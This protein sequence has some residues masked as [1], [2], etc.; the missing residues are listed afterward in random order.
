[1]QGKDFRLANNISEL[2]LRYVLS[3]AYCNRVAQTAISKC[4]AFPR[5]ASYLKQVCTGIYLPDI[6]AK[7]IEA[8]GSVSLLSGATIV[9]YAG[10][11]KD[12][13]PEGSD[14]MLDPASI[15]LEAGR[16]VDTTSEWPID[17]RWIVDYNSA[18]TR[19]SRSGMNFR[20]VNNASYEGRV[21]MAVSYTVQGE[22]LLPGAPQVMS[23]AEAQLG[24]CY[25]FRNRTDL[26]GWLGENTEL[27]FDAFTAIPFRE[28]VLFGD[29]CAASFAGARVVPE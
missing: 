28:R 29:A 10:N 7:Y 21:E 16:E 3:L 20:I 12:M 17:D 18:T 25:R 5:G 24:A 19:A 27:L 14:L 6:L 9:P 13:F 23:E 2:Q 8:I 4:Y 26:P 15:L 1:M 11:Y 22:L